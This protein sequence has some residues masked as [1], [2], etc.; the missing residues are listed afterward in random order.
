MTAPDVPLPETHYVIGTEG[1]GYTPDRVWNEP[2][3][4]AEQMRARDAQWEARLVA[5]VKAERDRCCSIIMGQ[6]GS[7]NVAQRTVDAIRG[8]R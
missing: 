4:T 2:A 1:D 5:A 3:Y 7:D 6:C 8:A